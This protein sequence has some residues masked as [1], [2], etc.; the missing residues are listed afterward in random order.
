MATTKNDTED[1]VAGLGEIGTPI[2]KLIVKGTNCYSQFGFDQ[3]K[4]LEYH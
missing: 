3:R 4:K 2:L 1:V